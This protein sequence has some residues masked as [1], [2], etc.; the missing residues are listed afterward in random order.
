M[1]NNFADELAI[2]QWAI[3]WTAA[4]SEVISIL[5]S[6]IDDAKAAA[7]LDFTTETDNYA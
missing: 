6:I 5:Q 1:K 3:D 2:A 7:D 4:K